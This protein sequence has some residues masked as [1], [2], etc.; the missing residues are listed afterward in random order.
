MATEKKEA[1]AV[2]F[3]RK[4]ISKDEYNSVYL[5]TPI[6]VVNGTIMDI[7]GNVLFSSNYVK[8]LK[9]VKNDNKNEETGA[10]EFPLMSDSGCLNDTYVFGFPWY[11]GDADGRDLASIKKEMYSLL[12]ETKD[13]KLVHTVNQDDTF[14]KIFIIKGDYKV[15]IEPD[16]Y[17]DLFNLIYGMAVDNIDEALKHSSILSPA[18]KIQE[19]DYLYSDELYDAVTKTVIC[20]D[21]QVRDVVTA[22]AKNS[23]L[24]SPSLK[25]TILLCGPT[26]V[27]KTEIFRTL[28]EQN[29]IPIAI[30]DSSEYTASGYKGKDTIE[31]LAHLIDK[32]DGDIERAQ[33]GIL[34]L[35]EVD[36]KAANGS[37][38]H[39]IYTTAVIDSLLKM[40][41][42]HEYSVPVEKGVEVPF[43]TSQL[44]FAFSGAFSGI[45][46]LAKNHKL[47]GFNTAQEREQTIKDLY[48]DETL[49]KF[50][51][52]PE[53]LG[54]CDVVVAMNQLGVD[55]F[56]RIINTSN[57][58]QLLLYKYLLRDIGIDFIYDDKTIEAIAKK[59]KELNLGARSIKKIV[60]N[61]LAVA[62]FQLF[63]RNS[64]SQLIISPETI[65]DNHQF[66]LR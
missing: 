20:Q 19:Q 52:K 26:G 24:T 41:E 2:I 38:D 22:I 63:S 66:I 8:S 13:Y 1:C 11:T 6:E 53:F 64:Y 42:G 18:I 34:V 3:E 39:D 37:S 7:D 47:M 10:Y 21:D 25:S 40:M 27:G 62:N 44:T 14:N 58:S 56:V 9:G 57:K 32:A 43:N 4:T 35:D 33:R 15:S 59:A 61:A 12:D 5:Y 51:L 60:E 36:K 54:R 31:M 16:D 48:N 50:G 55:D 46:K 45:E 30:E 49:K 23:R 65:E 17:D 29:I 28:Q